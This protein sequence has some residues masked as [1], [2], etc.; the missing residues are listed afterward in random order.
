MNRGHPLVIQQGSFS[1]PPLYL[2][3]A[4]TLSLILLFIMVIYGLFHPLL[5]HKLLQNKRF[6][7]P[8]YFH[9]P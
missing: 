4:Q 6:A 2:V 7:I 1:E 9:I 8:N 3:P 5:G